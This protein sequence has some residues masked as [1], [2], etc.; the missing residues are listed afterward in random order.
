MIK[1]P[2]DKKKHIYKNDVFV[3]LF[4]DAIRFLMVHQFMHCHLQS[5]SQVLVF[6]PF[7]T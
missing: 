2:F 4:K 3:E 1:Q 5:D 6:T 7:I